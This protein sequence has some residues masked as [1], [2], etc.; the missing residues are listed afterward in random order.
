MAAPP[1]LDGTHLPDHD[2]WSER[3]VVALGQNPSAFTGPG[4]NTYLV[5]TGARRILLDA[6]QGV[7]A[8]LDVLE[9]AMERSGCT[10]LQEIVLTHGHADHMG[11]L[12][13]VLERFGACPVSKL[14]WPGVD[15]EHDVPLRAL[16]DGARVGTEGATLRAIHTPGHAPDHLCF[17]LEEE[18]ALFSGDNVLGIGTTVI[19]ATSGDLG[20]Y[21]QSLGRMRESGLTRIYPAHGPVIADGAAKIDEYL[22]HRLERE[23]QIVTVLE[24]GPARPD[25]IVRV[26]YAA[27]PA[28]LHGAAAQSVTQHLM[29]LEREERAARVDEAEPLTARWRLT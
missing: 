4:T 15:E 17:L 13:S 12:R 19:P 10:G 8:Y 16:A 7:P 27:Y 24:G 11:G 6:G 29:K 20:A 18:R 26:V 1:I 14:P 2:R 5:G 22:A 23:R 9:A 28:H 25:E 21:L 3:V